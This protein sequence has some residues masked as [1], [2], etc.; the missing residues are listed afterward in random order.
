MTHFALASVQT[1][2]GPAVALLIGKHCYTLAALAPDLAGIDMLGVLREWPRMF[3]QLKSLAESVQLSEAMIEPQIFTPV[4]YPETL[5]AVGANYSGHLKEMGLKIEKWAVMPFF[6]RPPKACLVGPGSTVRIP[7]STN[8]FDWECELAVVVGRTLRHA[9]R[10]EASAGIAGYTIG[11][12]LSC[13]DLMTV[14]N[15]LHSDLIRGKAQDTMA[16]CGPAIV[17]AE[18][19]GNIED[20]RIQLAVND[21]PMMD[22][23]TSEMM[24]KCDEILSTISSYITLQPGDICFT[25]SPSGSAGAHGNRWLKPGDRICA[26]IENLGVLNVTMMADG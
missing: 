22:A 3:E 6:M 1:G 16:P 2:F 20:L 14:D 18:F 25:G 9:S 5:L 4:L 13:R 12:D 26:E 23:R 8:K 17:P 21:E 24:Y 15:E 19:V 10:K 7:R 11:L